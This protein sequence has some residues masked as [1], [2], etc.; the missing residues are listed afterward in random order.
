MCSRQREH[1]GQVVTRVCISCRGG[2]DTRQLPPLSCS[3]ALLNNDT[4]VGRTILHRLENLVKD[5][6]GEHGIPIHDQV[7]VD[8]EIMDTLTLWTSMKNMLTNLIVE[9][10]PAIV[11]DHVRTMQRNPGEK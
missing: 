9:S 1:E 11:M 4:D 6:M 5:Q 10:T 7:L 2:S 3:L 8:G